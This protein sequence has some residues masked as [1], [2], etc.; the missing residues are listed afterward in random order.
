M[1][2]DFRDQTFGLLLLWSFGCLVSSYNR[3]QC[4]PSRTITDSFSA[5]NEDELLGN[6]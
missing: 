3:A 1:R 2:Y 5:E 6:G 4:V